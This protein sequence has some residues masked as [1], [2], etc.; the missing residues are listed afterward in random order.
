MRK[1]FNN[2][3]FKQIGYLV[4]ALGVIFAA[5]GIALLYDPSITGANIGAGLLI[6]LGSSVVVAGIILTLVEPAE[7]IIKK[8]IKK[9]L[10]KPAK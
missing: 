4:I 10:K 6:M 5:T 1:A 7:K 3:T 2:S 8:E 9:S